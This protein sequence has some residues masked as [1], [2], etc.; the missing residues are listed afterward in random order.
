MLFSEAPSTKD[1]LESHQITIPKTGGE[2]FCAIIYKYIIENRDVIG[3]PKGTSKFPYFFV[4]NDLCGKLAG[5]LQVCSKA[6]V[7]PDNATLQ[8][9]MA[10][11]FDSYD[12]PSPPGSCSFWHSMSREMLADIC[13]KA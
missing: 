1:F 7:M 8:S 10:A 12:D 11:L 9:I 5:F 6:G 4:S 2:R 13:K 3:F